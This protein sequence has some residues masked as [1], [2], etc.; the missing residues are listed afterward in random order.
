MRR[1]VAASVPA[2]EPAVDRAEYPPET[3]PAASIRRMPIRTANGVTI[4]I[5]SE[6][7]RKRTI[8]ATSADQRT[9]HSNFAIQSRIFSGQT[10]LG[11]ISTAASDRTT[12]KAASDGRRSARRPPRA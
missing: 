4:P 7:G 1:K 3:V 9:S 8:A 10:T 5:A 11:S 2:I 6:A 12:D